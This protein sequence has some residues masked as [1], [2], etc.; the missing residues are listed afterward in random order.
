MFQLKLSSDV[1]IM[2]N[3]LQISYALEKTRHRENQ[4]VMTAER[5]EEI[6]YE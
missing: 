5:R 4:S 6:V 1:R 3:V 2:D